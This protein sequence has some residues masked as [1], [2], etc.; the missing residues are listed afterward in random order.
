MYLNVILK[1]SGQRIGYRFFSCPLAPL[2]R[3]SATQAA[4]VR[5]HPYS[6]RVLGCSNAAGKLTQQWLRCRRILWHPAADYPRCRERVRSG[7]VGPIPY[8]DPR[9][10][11]PILPRQ[12]FLAKHKHVLKILIHSIPK[13]TPSM[14]PAA[15][16]FIFLSYP[17]TTCF[18]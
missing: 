14:L 13:L 8:G 1:L 7:R 9:I 11:C 6:F 15:V 17:E 2:L 10:S 3:G 12:Y 16:P 4:I 5:S 18:N